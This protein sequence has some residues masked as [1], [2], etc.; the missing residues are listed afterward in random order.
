VNRYFAAVSTA[1]LL[2][3]LAGCTQA[4]PDTHDA[5]VKA[6]KDDEVQWNKDFAAKDLEKI[7]THYADDAV[8]AY[9]G[10]PASSGKAAIRGVYKELV[11]DPVLSIKFEASRV[12]VAKSGDLA[13]AQGFYTATETDPNTKGP[14]VEKGSYTDVYKKQPDGSWKVVSDSVSPDAPPPA[15]P[16]VTK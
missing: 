14:R 2:G 6:I 5:D 10:M 15:P 7:V 13:Y 3:L 8:F 16:P 1:A 9:G 11:A 12:E 4:P